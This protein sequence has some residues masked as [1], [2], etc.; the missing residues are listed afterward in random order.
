MLKN[1]W[2][3]SLVLDVLPCSWRLLSLVCIG[4]C[5]PAC[6]DQ[7]HM[8]NRCSGLCEGFITPHQRLRTCR[9]RCSHS[10]SEGFLDSETVKLLMIP[11]KENC[12]TATEVDVTQCTKKLCHGIQL[13]SRVIDPR[14]LELCTQKIVRMPFTVSQ[15]NGSSAS[16]LDQRGPLNREGHRDLLTE[17]KSTPLKMQPPSGRRVVPELHFYIVTWNMNGKVRSPFIAIFKMFIDSQVAKT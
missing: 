6:R 9:E 11:E 1:S 8:G 14:L 15:L 2:F 17:T 3:Q 7:E 12:T 10:L 5:W 13:E 16:G 4:Y